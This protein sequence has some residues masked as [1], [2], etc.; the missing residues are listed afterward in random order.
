MRDLAAGHLKGAVADEHQRPPPAGN[1]H[2]EGRWNREAHRAVVG[3]GDAL[4]RADVDAGEQRVAGV[5]DERHLVV[6]SDELV[7]HVDRVAHL[8]RLILFERVEHFRRDVCADRF[9][10][11]ARH[12]KS[13]GVGKSID[14]KLDRRVLEMVMPDIHVASHYGDEIVAAQQIGRHA[15][16]DVA[17]PLAEQ[18]Q[19]IR[20]LDERPHRSRT[21]R[22]EVGADE[23]P[24]ARGKDAAAQERGGHRNAHALG[25]ANHLLDEREAVHLDTDNQHGALGA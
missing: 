18:K 7:Q 22:A 21:H 3:G 15:E 24:M 13:G 25:E 14:E 5:G 9:D 17:E 12:W 1:L 6:L 20:L 23:L 4:I 11:I 19:A 16:T 2:A 8:D 10:R